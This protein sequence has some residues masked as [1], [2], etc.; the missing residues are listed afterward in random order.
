MTV[1]NKTKAN[2]IFSLLI[3]FI[4]IL[5]LFIPTGFENPSTTKNTVRVKARVIGVNNDDIQ[6]YG[7]VTTGSQTLQI[8]ILTGKF[9]GNTLKSTN[10]L[11]GQLKTDKIFHVNDKALV[12][13]RLNKDTGKIIS[14]R[15]EDIFRIHIEIILFLLFALFLI[16]FARW[17]GFKALLS[18]IFTALMIWKILI[19]AFLK[20]Y[21]PIIVSLFIVSL[22]TSVII[23]LISGFS[24]KG[25]VAL[26]GSIV[27]IALTSI[28]ALLFGHFFN[29]PGTVKEF[30]E[31]LLY[32]GFT[33][34]KFSDMF[35]S[36]IFISAAGAVMDVAMDISASQNELIQKNPELKSKELILS[37]F[38]IAYPVIGT[39][40]TTL[41]FA[42][43]G[44]FLFIFMMF[45]TKGTPMINIC[46]INY[47]AAEILHT[48]VGSFG[49]V[50]VAPATSIIGGYIYTF[51]RK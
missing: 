37:G 50:L 13:L 12:L 39:M 10:I 25:L 51:Q 38:N 23:V 28:M 27:G 11:M 18:F 43:S 31:A 46:N 41:L 36:A 17:T 22:T 16:F 2:I 7:I 19:P 42:Y 20:G 48:L 15:A 21:P 24:R 4:C 29:V 33:N 26:S 5:L 30:S 35:L 1:N 8:K 14:A 47:I 9:K 32:A 45:M 40:T 6:N 49:L 44:S 34:L 3:I